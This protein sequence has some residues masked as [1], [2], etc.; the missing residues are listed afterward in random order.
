MAADLR[1]R[2]TDLAGLTPTGA[3][4]PDLWAR[5]VRRRRAG[6]AG[7]AALVAAVVL[8][9]G[10][11][12]W[13]I[14][15]GEHRIQPADTRGTAHLP[16]RIYQPSPW[17][18]TF[19]GPPG[20]LVALLPAEHKTILHTTQGLVGVTADSGTY[21]FLDLP[22]NAV[23]DADR[24]DA[25]PALSPDGRHVAFWTTGTPSGTPN[26]HLLGMTITGVGVYDVVTGAV[27]ESP[28]ATVHGLDPGLLAW[29]DSGTLVLGLGQA[30][31]GD[32]DENSCCAGHWQGLATWTVDDPAGPVQLT[33]DL[34]PF[35]DHYG[36]SAGGGSLL[37]S[38]S[39]QRI[40]LIDPSPPGSDQVYRLSRASEYAVLAPSRQRVCVVVGPGSG[41]L[42]VGRLP[43]PEGQRTPVVAL[44]QVS[45]TLG[46][47]RPVAWQD[48]EH[49][50]V[51]HRIETRYR[52]V[53]R[54][55]LVDVR[56]GGARALVRSGDAGHPAVGDGTTLARDLLGATVVHASP[57]PTPWDRREV[58]IGLVVVLSI[59][60]GLLLLT[61][62]VR[63][64]ARP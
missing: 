28:L 10:L 59:V 23:A 4:P 13:T 42:M 47:V 31:A 21:G 14:R 12:S 51:M 45:S 57:P 22:A 60:G 46:F 38:S 36:T 16:D 61:W 33:G 3:P 2:L 37:S 30:S 32:E 41:R 1:D 24:V 25:P 54:L 26:T 49:V 43:R 9:V 50:V 20:Q 11:G 62:G 58:A 52:V 55:D 34:P 6:Q 64:A 63:R 48:N 56:T 44:R 19:E 29:S 15:S 39:G 53:Y 40:D 17:L 35:V 8:I 7:T 5:G 27:Q 18:P